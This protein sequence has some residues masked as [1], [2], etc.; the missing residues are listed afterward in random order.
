MT[1]WTLQAAEKSGWGLS[2]SGAGLILLVFP[3]CAN[4]SGN[5][6]QAY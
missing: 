1:G 6:S 2:D 4:D 3:A 5:S